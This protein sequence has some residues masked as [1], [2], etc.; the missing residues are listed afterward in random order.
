MLKLMKKQN[1]KA[2]GAD[3]SCYDDDSA[4]SLAKHQA[5]VPTALVKHLRRLQRH[6]IIII[7]E[8]F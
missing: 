4:P 6:I 5:L 8:D 1:H 3:L 2:Y 7:T